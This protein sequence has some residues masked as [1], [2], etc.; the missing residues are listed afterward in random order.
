MA[1][2]LDKMVLLL[3][4]GQRKLEKR[5]HK[6]FSNPYKESFKVES[7]F[8]NAITAFYN[9]VRFWPSAQISPFK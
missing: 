3:E 2:G 7:R 4:D 5:L 8:G 9:E 6:R 1:R